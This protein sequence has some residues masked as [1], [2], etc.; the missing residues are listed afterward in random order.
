MG[1]AKAGVEALTRQLAVELS[2]QKIRVNTVC[3][4]LIDTD[5]LNHFPKGT[6][7]I[8]ELEL[9]NSKELMMSR[10]AQATPL[11][12]IG[13]PEDLANAVWLLVQP[14]AAWITG[15]VLVVDGGFSLL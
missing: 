3:G 9:E 14:E 4:G 12:R 11:G 10:T 5:A 1:A 8:G 15:Q 6:F 13:T 2:P 7:R